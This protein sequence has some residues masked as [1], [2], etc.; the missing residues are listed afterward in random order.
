MPQ[1]KGPMDIILNRILIVEDEQSHANVIKRHL[2]AHNPLVDV[3]IAHSLQQCAKEIEA[4]CPD[5]LLLDLNLPDGSAID[6]LKNKQDQRPYPILIMTSQGSETLAVEA[7]KSGFLDYIV[8]SPESFATMPRTVE[9]A[10]REWHTQ[11]EHHSAQLALEES[12]LRFRT[13]LEDVSAVAVQGYRSDGTVFYWN[14]ASQE[15]Y[16]YSATEAFGQ[17]L[18]DLII[19]ESMQQDVHAA[20]TMMVQTR[21]PIPPGELTLRHKDGSEVFVHSSHTVNCLP[22]QPTEIYCIDIDISERKRHETILATQLRL[23]QYSLNHTTK[24]LIQSFLDE[25]EK[26]TNSQIGFFHFV[27]EDQKSLHLQ[28]WSRRTMEGACTTQ[29]E[30][31]HYPLHQA[32]VWADCA[33]VRKPIIH[34]DYSSLSGKKGLPAGH[35]PVNREL[36][37]PVFRDDKIVAIFGVGNKPS[38]YLTSDL[39][40]IQKLADLAWD[41]IVRKQTEEEVLRARQ[42]WEATFDAMTDM[43]TIHDQR[44]RIVRSNEAARNFVG[45]DKKELLGKLCCEALWNQVG[46]CQDCPLAQTI[47]DGQYH[48]S[49]ISYADNTMFFHVTTSPLSTSDGE[50]YFIHVARDITKSKM[51]ELELRKLGLAVEQSPA[52]V[53]IT[54][55]DREI[56]YVNARFTEL[57]GYD[58]AEVLGQNPRILSSGAADIVDYHQLWTH[59]QAGEQWRGEFLNKHKSGRLFWER[60]LISPLRDD[61][62]QITHYVG[63]KEDITT[64]K[65][66]EKELEYQATHDTLTGL[67]NRALLKDRLAQSIYYAQRSKRIVAVALLDLDRFKVINDTLGHATGDELLCQIA[68]RLQKSVRETDTVARFGGDEFMVLLTEVA[69]AQD[70]NLVMQKILQIFTQPYE[71]E[72]RLLTLSASIGIS[73][74]PQNSSDPETL[75]RYADIAMYQ[76]KKS[77]SAFSFYSNE[78]DS[79]GL[80][81]LE[82]EHDLHG[83]LQRQEFCLHYQPKL[84]LKTGS[85]NGCEALL[86]WQHPDL[87]MVSPGE[88]IPLAEETGLIVP[89]GTWVLEEACRQSLVWQTAGLPPIQIAVNLS[90]RQ[91][92]Q[93]DLVSTVNTI[94]CDSGLDPGFLELELTESMIMDDPQG[95]QTTLIALRN[96]GVS[97]SLDDFGTG[98][99]SLNYL[100]RFPV[101]HLK[102]DQSFIRDIATS[103][104]RTAVVSSIIHIAHNLQLTAIAEGVETT[105][106][107]AFLIA[108][109]CDAM[110][111]YLFSKP[112]PADEFA[113]LLE[114]GTCLPVL[115]PGMSAEK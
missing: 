23:S 13:L 44:M 86:R 51:A 64:Q 114:K 105:E 50:R 31:R 92:R 108:N 70:L 57:T 96:L 83:A 55:L 109:K 46:I 82:L 34:N 58:K 63:V 21:Q 33:R 107:L 16:G 75:I 41:L 47:E 26:L 17:H 22:G 29:P 67:A 54:N 90:A 2:L 106:Q 104:A 85:I 37:L 20:M 91:F 12:E 73:S 7:L 25:A 97:L 48:S 110:Q 38:D 5:L 68:D 6:Y 45:A 52:S 88:F 10:L 59:L 76:S 40:I 113:Q 30:Q 35:V 101:D 14:K 15:L 115:V 3:A 94:L 79:F 27:G 11:Q 112:L 56:E 43:V 61:Q 84:D 77:G 53:M 49:I 99:S 102:I 19:P 100:S 78:M 42:E 18:C 69:A 8:K 60:A 74:Y 62:G 9:R 36:V 87:G 98:Y 24:E 28:D 1:L 95:A 65:A 4:C 103:H 93:G 32:G 66:Y 80:E 71:I 39:D 111:G 72:Q 81:T 89:I